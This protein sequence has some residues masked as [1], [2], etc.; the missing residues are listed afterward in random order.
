[1]SGFSLGSGLG[2]LIAALVTGGLIS[3]YTQMIGWPFLAI[4][5]LASVIVATFVSPRG[6]FITVVSIPLLFTFFL[7]L[8]GTLNAYFSLPEGQ[9]SLGRTSVLVILYPLVQFFPVL[10]MVT[11]GALLITVVRYQLLKRLNDDIRRHELRQRRRTNEANRRSVR[12]AS[13]SRH[14]P[15]RTAERTIER[16]AEQPRVQAPERTTQRPAQPAGKQ[17]PRQRFAQSTSIPASQ[18]RE[19]G[20]RSRNRNRNGNKVTVDELLARRRRER[21]ASKGTSTSNVRRRLSDDLYG[22]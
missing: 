13:R 21:D 16:T 19:R 20:R 9:T 14:L 1:M 6:L 15:E 18:R 11:L 8:T 2:I 10:A 12:E 22:D 17:K 3:L 5:A 7:L 4:F